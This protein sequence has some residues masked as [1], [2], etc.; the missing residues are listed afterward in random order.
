MVIAAGA[1]RFR[2]FAGSPAEGVRLAY[3]V[4]LCFPL[5]AARELRKT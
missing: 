2:C 5:E 1:T 3:G 4:G